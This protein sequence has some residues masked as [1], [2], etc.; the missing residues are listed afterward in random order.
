LI[1]SME[2]WRKIQNNDGQRHIQIEIDFKRL[3]I[4]HHSSL[5]TTK[6]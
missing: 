4:D 5:C 2:G 1:T 6:N 3:I